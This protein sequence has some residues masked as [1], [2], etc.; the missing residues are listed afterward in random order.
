VAGAESD[1]FC[2]TEA[3]SNSILGAVLVC[4]CAFANPMIAMATAMN[5][6]FVMFFVQPDAAI[7]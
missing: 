4:D 5:F 6:I 7:I 1:L 2:L 3:T